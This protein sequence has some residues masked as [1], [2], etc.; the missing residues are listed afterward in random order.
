MSQSGCPLGDRILVGYILPEK[1]VKNPENDD[2]DWEDDEEEE[3]AQPDFLDMKEMDS[4]SSGGHVFNSSVPG[5]NEVDFLDSVSGKRCRVMGRFSLKDPWWE[6]TCTTRAAKGKLV[7]RGYPAYRLRSDLQGDPDHSVLSLFLTA[8]G[9]DAQ[10]V[11]PFFAWLPMGRKVE[12]ANLQE[13]LAEFE[14]GEQHRALAQQIKALV[15]VSVAGMRVTAASLYPHVMRYLPTLLPGRFTELLSRGK[16]SQKHPAAQGATQIEEE[17]EEEDLSL[18]AK[19]EEMI[20]T[21]VWKL[22][23]NYVMYKE[24]KVVHCEAQLRSFHE[25]KLFQEIPLKQRNA[26]QVYD[27]LKNHCCRTGSTYTELPTL[28]DEVRRGCSSVMEVEVWDAVHFL[29]ELGVVVRDRQKVAL[30]NLHSY[31]TG[32]AECLRCLVQEEPWVI[33]LDVIEVLTA[34]ALERLRKTGGDGGSREDQ[35]EVD[36]DAERKADELNERCDMDGSAAET[37]RTSAAVRTASGYSV[38]DHIKPEP[39]PTD[40]GP[41]VDLDPAQGPPPVDLDP[42]QVRAAEMICFNPVTVISGKGGCGK[43]TVVSLVFKAALQQSPEKEV[44]KACWDFENDSLGSEAWEEADAWEEE[45]LS[46]SLLSQLEGEVKDEKK[47]SSLWVLQGEDEVLLTAPTGRAASLLTKRTCFKAYTL[48]QV[49]WSFMQAKKDPNG[50][51]EEWKFASVRV[52]VVDEGSLVCV[53]LLHSVLTMLTKHAQLRKFVILGDVRQ[54]PSIQPGNTL[55]GLFHSLPVCLGDVRQLP[56]IQPGNTLYGLFHSLPVC[57]GDVRQLPSIQPGNTLYGLFHSLPV[58]LGDVRQLPSIQ[59]GNTLYDLFHSLGRAHWAIEMR[60][61]HRAESQLIVNNAGQI[62]E[63]GMNRSFRPLHY[64]AILDLNGSYTMP[65]EDKRFIL[66]LLPNT[67]SDSDYDLQVAIELLLKAAPG[68]RNDATSQFIAFRRKECVLINELCCKHYCDH[69]TK[70]NKN[71]LDFQPRD[72]VCCTKNGYVTDR[73]KEVSPEEEDLEN[74]YV[75]DTDRTKR[76]LPGL[77]GGERRRGNGATQRD[78]SGDKMKTK[79]KNKERLCNGEI[80]FIKHDVTEEEA[81]SQRSRKQRYLT[82]DDGDGRELCVSFRELQRECK[83]QHAWARTIHTFQGSETET[84]VYVLGNGSVQ[85]WKHVYTA[86]TRGQKRVYVI[87]KREGMASAIKRRIIPRNTRL[88]TLVKE[89]LVQ[90]G[91]EGQDQPDQNQ[92]QPGTPRR[93]APSFGPT[94]TTPLASQTPSGSLRTPYKTPIAAPRLISTPSLAVPLHANRVQSHSTSV[95]PRKL[96]R[97][98]PPTAPQADASDTSLM[99]DITFSQAYTW[100]PMN[101]SSEDPSQE[102][103]GSCEEEEE[104]IEMEASSSAVEDGHMG[105]GSHLAARSGVESTPSKRTLSPDSEKQNV[106]HKQIKV[107]PFESPLGCSRLQQL[108]LC[109]PTSHGKRLFQGPPSDQD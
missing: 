58:C 95:L 13:V 6:A 105:K 31:E 50:A 24:L 100:S 7:L 54:L 23:F 42:D 8:C 91:A 90:P 12:F 75:S 98:E 43:T 3:D 15:S 65:S 4:V 73:N 97:N 19:I 74:S 52:L 48:H 18:L 69:R 38:P 89:L 66:I 9:V 45:A 81:G 39:A 20:K 63:M 108:A 83:L 51:P 27:S 79:E 16:K 72:K 64:D 11:V 99:D 88:G 57:L 76:R 2:S 35:G 68:L 92:P 33:P 70:N 17:E 1:K 104:G 26:L 87:A 93:A 32:I 22:G 96:W 5:R 41:P 85:T 40:Q 71:R 47:K 37:D 109:T 61:N 55:Y 67:D 62:A 46:K 60:T 21:D 106:T 28:C 102:Q 30:Q 44:R 84:I 86:V 59:P 56:S 103:P 14:E 94:Q 77:D 34:S 101:S 25:C 49:V 10:F 107:E 53:Q 78:G 29:K 80:F 36:S 82:L